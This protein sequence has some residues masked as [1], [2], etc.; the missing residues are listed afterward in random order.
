[1]QRAPFRA[2]TISPLTTDH[3]QS[4]PI[5]YPLC[6]VSL[7]YHSF[8]LRFLY[9]RILCSLAPSFLPLP[10]SFFS[11]ILSSPP[12]SENFYLFHLRSSL[13]G[14]I[15]RHSRESVNRL[16][17]ERAL[18]IRGRRNARR[19]TITSFVTLPRLDMFPPL[20]IVDRRLSLF[21]LHHRTNATNAG[22]YAKPP[23][24]VYPFPHV[25]SVLSISIYLSTYLSIYLSCSLSLVYS[26]LSDAQNHRC[27]PVRFLRIIT[28]FHVRGQPSASNAVA[29]PLYLL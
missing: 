16:H 13:D 20:S 28:C 17:C 26:V 18:V 21:L 3:S 24:D 15:D 9:V 11:P 22:I 23:N 8:L 19:R 25:L 27:S 2:H 1:M 12:L 10:V 14:S 4:P 7:F 29:T 6:F 5:R